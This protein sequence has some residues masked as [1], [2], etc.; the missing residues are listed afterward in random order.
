M[1]QPPCRE[2][3]VP[4]V[5]FARLWDEIMLSALTSTILLYGNGTHLTLPHV[6]FVRHRWLYILT[7]SLT[8]SHSVVVCIFY[9][10]HYADSAK[11]AQTDDDFQRSWLMV[12]KYGTVVYDVFL[13][14]LPFVYRRFLIVSVWVAFMSM[15]YNWEISTL[16]CWSTGRVIDPVPGAWFITNS[17]H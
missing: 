11:L 2:W 17:S 10:I 16:D 1:L 14:Q 4:A 6:F 12:L 15:C 5:S 3:I 13:A 7:H 8:H 9:H